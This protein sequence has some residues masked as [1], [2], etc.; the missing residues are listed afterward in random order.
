MSSPARSRSAGVIDTCSTW[1]ACRLTT[2][3]S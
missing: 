2:S 1:T 3:I